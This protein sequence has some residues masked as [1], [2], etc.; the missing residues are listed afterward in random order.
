MLLDGECMIGLIYGRMRKIG[1]VFGNDKGCILEIGAS[2]YEDLG[3]MSSN[4]PFLFVK[5]IL[6]NH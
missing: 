5:M 6:R 1:T 3:L 2:W 4:R